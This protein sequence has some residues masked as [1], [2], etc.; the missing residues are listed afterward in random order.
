MTERISRLEAA[1]EALRVAAGKI[2]REGCR[3]E[4]GAP[5]YEK[6]WRPA[7]F[8]LWGKLIPP[9]ALGPRCYEHAAR[10]VPDDALRPGSDW[11]ILDLRPLRA[12]PEAGQ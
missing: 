1:H 3:E 8:V 6:C 10:H 2:V 4:L 5:T 11:A 7:E 9:E 12:A